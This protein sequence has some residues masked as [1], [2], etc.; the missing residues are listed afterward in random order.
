MTRR[1]SVPRSE[2]LDLHA[3]LKSCQLLRKI[4]HLQ[5]QACK[6]TSTACTD[7]QDVGRLQDPLGPMGPAIA[8]GMVEPV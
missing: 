8:Q 3:L 6:A 1:L 4:D 7:E 2:V 5:C